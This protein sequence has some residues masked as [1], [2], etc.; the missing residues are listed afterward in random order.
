MCNRLVVCETDFDFI[1]LGWR[2]LVDSIIGLLF[3]ARSTGQIKNVF[4]KSLKLFLCVT[5]TGFLQ[6]I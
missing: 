4:T 6:A 1:H 3:K 5:N 2:N